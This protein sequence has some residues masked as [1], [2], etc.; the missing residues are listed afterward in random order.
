MVSSNL[1]RAYSIVSALFEAAFDLQILLDQRDE[2]YAFIGGLAVLRWGAPR[3]TRDVDI[4][5]FCPFGHE[6]EASAPLLGAGYKGRVADA[7]EFARRSRVLLLEAPNGV[8]I[9]VAFAALPFEEGL[10]ARSTLYE[11]E[12]NR[13][14][15]TCSAEDLI[16]TKLF[17]F[18]PRDVVDAESVVIRQSGVL[19]WRYIEDNLRSLAEVKDEPGIMIEFKRLRG[20]AIR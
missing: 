7:A 11:F 17:A 20:A 13:A 18:R 12:E 16:V 3:F 15:R 4:T 6:A 14:V 19:D 1:L 9:D 2:R 8:P 5:L 10:I